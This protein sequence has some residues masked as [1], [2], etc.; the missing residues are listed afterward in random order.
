MHTRTHRREGA[1]MPD[2]LQH[3]YVHAHHRKDD[4]LVA[5]GRWSRFVAGVRKP[6]S[7]RRGDV[8]GGRAQP[9]TAEL[10]HVRL[11]QRPSCY[12]MD[13]S[14]CNLRN[15]ACRRR[16][17]QPP[18]GNCPFPICFSPLN[19]VGATNPSLF[20]AVTRRCRESGALGGAGQGAY[21]AY[22]IDTFPSFLFSSSAV[23]SLSLTSP[24]LARRT[25][26]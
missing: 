14:R 20:S 4:R 18:P 5:G 10:G 2:T 26:R 23:R 15:R 8:R 24:K 1:C 6:A 12:N 21:P 25:D 9:E 3:P 7:E 11:N 17:R 19:G 22:V 13:P 16:F